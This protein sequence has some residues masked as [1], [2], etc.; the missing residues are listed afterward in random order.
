M[1]Y[2]MKNGKFYDEHARERRRSPNLCSKRS[3]PRARRL[4]SKSARGGR[5]NLFARSSNRRA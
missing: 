1:A 2:S 5:R 3:K 4:L